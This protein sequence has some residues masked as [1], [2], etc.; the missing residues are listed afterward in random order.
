MKKYLK[1]LMKQPSTFKGLALLAGSALSAGGVS[2]LL[3]VEI[4]NTGDPQFG[5]TVATLG[6]LVLGAWETLRNEKKGR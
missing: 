5:G 2:E 3:T 6:M 4:P 1:N